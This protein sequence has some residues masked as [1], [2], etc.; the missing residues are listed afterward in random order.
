MR[1]VLRWKRSFGFVEPDSTQVSTPSRPVN[2]RTRPPA[3]QSDLLGSGGA[4]EARRYIL[5]H[6]GQYVKANANQGQ[7]QGSGRAKWSWE[8]TRPLPNLA[9]ATVP[10]AQ[11][12]LGRANVPH[13]DQ[14]ES[15]GLPCEQVRHPCTGFDFPFL[16]DYNKVTTRVT[17]TVQAAST[18][19]FAGAGFLADQPDLLF[20]AGHTPPIWCQGE[21]SWVFENN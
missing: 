9:H 8:S 20:L 17:I 6:V 11:L 10:G 5:R 21:R 14:M 7:S 16:D 12:R 19:V 15:E 13:P 2:P 4:C 1:S 18:T 3:L